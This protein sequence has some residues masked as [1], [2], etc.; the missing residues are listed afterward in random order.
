MKPSSFS[1]GSERGG[2]PLP[3]M[4]SEQDAALPLRGLGS[5]VTSAT[6][7]LSGQP[8]GAGVW[9]QDGWRLHQLRL[10]AIERDACAAHAVAAVRQARAFGVRIGG[11]VDVDFTVAM[12]RMRRLRAGISDNDS[13]Y[14]LA[15]LGVDVFLGEAKFVAPDVVEVNRQKLGFLSSGHRNGRPGGKPSDP[16]ARGS[17]LPHQ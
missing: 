5:L 11:P 7:L 4:V 9:G 12:E 14:R 16:G 2:R 3:V 15:K 8:P 10:R 1:I 17:R 6:E 13:A